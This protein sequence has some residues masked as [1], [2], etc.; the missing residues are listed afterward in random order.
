MCRNV[1]MHVYMGVCPCPSV[2][3][4]E[5]TCTC[6]LWGKHPWLLSD[7]Q[8]EQALGG[9]SWPVPQERWLWAPA[10]PLPPPPSTALAWPVFLLPPTHW[11]AKSAH[12]PAL[13][14]LCGGCRLHSEGG[15]RPVGQLPPWPPPLYSHPL[16]HQL[17]WCWRSPL[18]ERSSPR[19]PQLLLLPAWALIWVFGTTTTQGSPPSLCLPFFLP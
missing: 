17:R 5:C 8:R 16:A 18:P 9:E 14:R 12:L 15:Q 13:R 19:Y 6:V 7:S 4:Y 2:C 3:V 10:A 11:W 1:C